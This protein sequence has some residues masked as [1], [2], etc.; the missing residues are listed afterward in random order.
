MLQNINRLYNVLCK[1]NMCYNSLCGEIKLSM[2]FYRQK[3]LL[4]L[5]EEFGGSLS[6]T[7]LQ[8]YLFLFS[9][10]QGADRKYFFVP[11]K[12]GCFSFQSYADRRYL[13][14]SEF[15][16]DTNIWKLKDASK[17]YF[18]LLTDSD[19]FK[20]RK[21]K[22][23]FIHLKGDK[24]I[25]YVYMNYPYYTINSKI[26]DRVLS[27][28]QKENLSN[29]IEIDFSQEEATKLFTLGYEGI[30]PEEYLNKLIKN[31]IK[32]VVDVRKNPLSRKYGFS[33][34]QLT[35]LLNDLGINYEHIPNLGIASEKRTNLNTISDYEELFDEYEKTVLI[36]QTKDMSEILKILKRDKRIALTCFEANPK[37]C[38]RSRIA[39]KLRTLPEWDYEIGEL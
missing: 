16:E 27:T 8:K 11:Y 36:K 6:N 39:K 7:D 4:G 33:K 23:D 3:I 15:I 34:N 14:A 30:S 38:H 25:E 21:F 2:L 29:I 10:I 19:R 35:V 9:E 12:Q 18:D 37:M 22:K 26:V 5:L 20:L 1:I 17:K 32:T 24:L 28:E 31:N 13:K